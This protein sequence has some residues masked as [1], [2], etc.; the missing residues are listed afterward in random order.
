MHISCQQCCQADWDCNSLAE[1]SCA[2]LTI[3]STFDR[4]RP[5]MAGDLWWKTTFDERRPLMEDD[6]WWE[7]NFDG[8]H[9]LMED[10]FCGRQPL[11]EDDIWWKTT[12]DDI[13]LL[14]E[15]DQKIRKFFIPPQKIIPPPD[16][17]NSKKIFLT[18]LPKMKFIKK[19]CPCRNCIQHLHYPA[20]QHFLYEQAGTE[21]CQDQLKLVSSFS[22][23]MTMYNP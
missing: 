11:I 12:F 19:T 17:F 7:M 18:S 4:I 3:K 8:R 13:Q 2:T 23:S 10:D 6:L 16:L 21:L 9:P 1:L 14:M 15:D 22:A 5:L 20:L